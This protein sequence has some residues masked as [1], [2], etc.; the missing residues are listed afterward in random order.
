MTVLPNVGLQV[1]A[2]VTL[3]ELIVVL[4]QQSAL[5][6]PAQTCSWAM[7]IRHLSVVANNGV[8]SAATWAGNLMVARTHTDFPSDVLLTFS[9]LQCM[10]TLTSSTGTRQVSVQ[11]FCSDGGNAVKLAVDEL[12]LSV[13]I[14]FAAA[15]QAV[16]SYK[17]RQRHQNTH[18]Y[19]N[20]GFNMSWTTGGA[21]STP[22]IANFNIW[23]GGLQVGLFQPKNTMAFLSNQPL[24]SATLTQAISLLDAEC[25]PSSLQVDYAALRSVGLSRKDGHLSPVVSPAY[26]HSLCL[27]T[28]Y[29]FFVGVLQVTG[30]A[31]PSRDIS[32]TGHTVRPISSGV[33][34]FTPDPSTAPIGQPMAKLTSYLQASGE[35]KYTDDISQPT[36]N[37]LYGAFV[38]ATVASATIQSLDASKALAMPGVVTFISAKDLVTVGASNN[39]GFFP[40]DEEIFASTQIT[41][42]GQSLGFIV[43]DTQAHANAA[44]LA[45]VANVTAVT[46]A[47]IVTLQQAIAAKSFFPDNTYQQNPPPV[48]NGDVTKGFAAS[49]YVVSGNNFTGGQAHFYVSKAHKRNLTLP[50]FRVPTAVS[51]SCPWAPRFAI[52]SLL[53][54]C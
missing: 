50:V 24:N 23:Y 15:N 47:P 20:A 37:A 7:L 41:A 4:E 13:T 51:R 25:T 30:Y 11:Q 45:V 21:G 8:R 52:S 12:V 5:L 54:I 22:T 31:V 6:P 9:T 34:T 43:A 3:A 16:D 32:A 19:L 1:G 28:F 44:A 39:C 35:I 38:Y 33:Q 29:A 53:R 40:G 46:T 14:P 42:T 2:A 10:L 27:S 49:K 48:V 17:V 26:R 36:T 18:A